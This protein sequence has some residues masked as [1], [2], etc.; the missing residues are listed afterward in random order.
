M[1]QLDTSTLDTM[2]A[3]YDAIVVQL[4]IKSDD[5]RTSKLAAMIAELAI[6]GERDVQEL[7]KRALAALQH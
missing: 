5:P 1:D 2:A 3:A 7:S 4:D 6:A